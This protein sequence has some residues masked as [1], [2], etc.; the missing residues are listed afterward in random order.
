MHSGVKVAAE[1]SSMHECARRRAIGISPAVAVSLCHLCRGI[2]GAKRL[3]RHG[4]QHS[5]LV[6][7]RVARVMSVVFPLA[8]SPSLCCP[9]VCAPLLSSPLAALRR[10][11]TGQRASQGSRESHRRERVDERWRCCR[12]RTLP[13]TLMR[14]ADSDEV[15]QY[16][17]VDALRAPTTSRETAGWRE[18]PEH[19]QRR[20]Y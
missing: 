7:L 20:H 13:C 8:P 15:Q 19:S 6:C 14:S 10:S 11:L 5:V 12:K 18:A 17:A 1:G 9:L 3:R 16:S 2:D 4:T